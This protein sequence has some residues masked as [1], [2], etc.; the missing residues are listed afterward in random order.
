LNNKQFI[1]TCFYLTSLPDFRR[2]FRHSYGGLRFDNIKG[3]TIE[4]VSIREILDGKL[5][6][7]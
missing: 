5:I 7:D 2:S 3:L 4:K 6:Y 1:S